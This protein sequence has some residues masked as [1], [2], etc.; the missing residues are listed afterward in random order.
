MGRCWQIF[1]CK[2]KIHMYCQY[3]M[4]MN[5][6][7]IHSHFCYYF[8]LLQANVQPNYCANGCCASHIFPCLNGGTCRETC[9]VT[10]E[11]F[12]C[13]CPPCFQG[14]YRE[15]GRHDLFL[16]VQFTVLKHFFI[17]KAIKL[18]EV[19]QIISDR[20]IIVFSRFQQLFLRV[21]RS[22]QFHLQLMLQQC[23]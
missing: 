22:L 6:F 20:F 5:K 2:G 13:S 4:Q 17:K 3:A 7:G 23:Q 1:P 15:I 8:G 19:V 21:D 11:R 16:L 14:K 18:S 9:D 10:R 12:N